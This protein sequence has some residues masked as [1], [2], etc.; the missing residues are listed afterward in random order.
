ML[1]YFFEGLNKKYYSELRSD[2]INEDKQI[3]SQKIE[4]LNQ[5]FKQ[6]FEA[7]FVR[8]SINLSQHVL[9]GIST[10]Y[11]VS[12]GVIAGNS[13]IQTIWPRV[14]TRS[15]VVADA[16]PFAF[17][18][19]HVDG[20]NSVKIPQLFFIED[21]QTG[22]SL[23]NIIDQVKKQ[24]QLDMLIGIGGGRPMDIL[25]FIGLHTQMKMVAFPTSLTSHVYASPKIHA[26]NPIK[27][28]GYDLTIDGCPPHLALLDI[29]I[30]EIANESNPRLIRAGLGDI[31][32]FFTARFDWQLA[33]REDFSQQNFLVEDVIDYI[34]SMLES[35]DVEAPLRTWVRDYLL[36]Q[37][38]LCHIT[39]WIGSA[40]ASGSEHLFALCAEEASNTTPLHGELV[41]LGSLIMSYVQGA[42]FLRIKKIIGKL[43]ITSS[44]SEIGL[45]KDQVIESLLMARERGRKKKRYTILEKIPYNRKYFVKL[46]DDLLV[47]KI[48]AI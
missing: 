26:L 15:V 43:G 48:I 45:T 2:S 36:I 24:K 44:L 40:P 9:N 1:S 3:L 7:E 8:Q 16:D 4:D 19:R 39:D 33:I 14:V 13:L 37:V 29:G 20:F 38:L 30:L 11:S 17:V 35:F 12:S 5:A 6:T 34:V 10:E 21:I 23:L 32:A 27:E 31:M 47:N 42:D 18:K 25:K 41:A 22:E 28:L 46:V